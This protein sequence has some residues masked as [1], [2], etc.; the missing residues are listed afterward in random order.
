MACDAAAVSVYKMEV[1][2]TDARHIKNSNVF[3]HIGELENQLISRTGSKKT[4]KL[5]QLTYE[6]K[7]C[8]FTCGSKVN[9]TNP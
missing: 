1:H 8:S 3:N 7:L 9:L 2:L 5:Q 6:C 4:A